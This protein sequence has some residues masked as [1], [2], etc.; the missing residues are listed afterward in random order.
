MNGWLT[1]C[2]VIGSSFCA[3]P[4]SH[5]DQNRLFSELV[6]KGVPIGEKLAVKLPAPTMSDGLS[7]AEQKRV[8]E[9]LIA[10]D[11][12]YSEFTRR[13]VV[14]PQ[15]LYLKSDLVPS[16]KAAPSRGLDVY[17]LVYGDFGAT[18]NQTFLNRLLAISR[19]S[20]AESAE[21]GGTEAGSTTL[22]PEQLAKRNIMV[23][24][25]DSGRA[26][27]IGHTRFDI[28]DRVRLSVTG[29][30][31]WSQTAE[32]VLAAVVV[33]RRFHGDSEFPN[34]WQSLK[35]TGDR[36]VIG[37]PQAYP[38]AGLYLKLTRLAEPAGAIFVEEHVV[39]TE[40]VGWFDGVNLLRSKLPPVVQASVRSIRREWQKFPPNAK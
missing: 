39:F 5:A 36:V 27:R 12:S 26:E 6:E 29:R 37:E 18:S 40:P 10:G 38:G 32:S 2:L 20:N 28:L 34:V 16:D 24:A 23:E 7:A 17:F 13:S 19:D 9:Q 35:K 21:P 31:S 22:S 25:S 15:L 1:T 3:D 4:S 33:D 11:Y 8:I 14:A 30:V